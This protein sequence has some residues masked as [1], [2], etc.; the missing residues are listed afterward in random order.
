MDV[1]KSYGTFRSRPGTASCLEIPERSAGTN[2]S[3]LSHLSDTRNHLS[4]D[5]LQTLNEL[6]EIFKDNKVEGP[7]L[8]RV[9]KEFNKNLG[10][11][12]QCTVWGI[13]DQQFNDIE[14]LK[15]HYTGDSRKFR[16]PVDRIAIKRHIPVR[17]QDSLVDVTSTLRPDTLG[18][19][20]WAA[21]QEVE[22][23]S[24]PPLRD[25]KN[26]VELLGWGFCLDVA[27]STKASPL[28]VPLLVL[29]RADM[30]LFEILQQ[31][32][33]ITS[34]QECYLDERDLCHLLKDVGRGLHALHDAGLS[35]GDLKPQNVL[36]FKSKSRRVT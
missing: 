34:T 10:S 16:W 20:L 24:H 18:H 35:H 36:V 7:Q 14:R 21:K 6:I 22:A 31:Q 28:Q 29:E 3:K 15:K 12:A 11:G 23:L 30:N 2:L 25:H 19:H 5:S 9:K 32:P 1:S 4:P 27:E 8:F 17:R 13:G 26:I 33:N